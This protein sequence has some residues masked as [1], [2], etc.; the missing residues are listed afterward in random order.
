MLSEMEKEA[1]KMMNGGVESKSRKGLPNFLAS[2]N[3]KYVK[4][5]YIYL[6]SLS[7]TFCFFFPPLL[8]LFIFASQFL[9][10]LAFP[11]SIFFLL[12]LYHFFTPSSVYLLNFSCYRPPDH[13]KVMFLP[14][15]TI[16]LFLSFS[17]FSLLLCR[18]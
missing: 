10:I 17:L 12:F 3:L 11:L 5:G 6:L 18:C 2:V 14:F 4:L 8:L 15:S 7:N 9:P 1:K 16:L 13:L